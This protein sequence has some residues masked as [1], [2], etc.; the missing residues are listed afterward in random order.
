LSSTLDGLFIQARDL[1]EQPIPTSTQ[2]GGLHGNIPTV[3]L[4]IQSAKPQIHLP[5][6]LLIWME[7]F[8]LAMGT[9]ELMHLCSW[10]GLFPSPLFFLITYSTSCLLV[11]PA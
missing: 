4:F 7:H 11:S 9:L 6:Q 5:M 3:L 10:H 1:R 8:L 2:A